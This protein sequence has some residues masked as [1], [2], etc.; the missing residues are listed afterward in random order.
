MADNYS[1]IPDG[2]LLVAVI[3]GW[4]WLLDWAGYR[5]PSLE[6]VVKPAAL[7]L[8]EDG[9]MLRQNMAKEFVTADELWGHLRDRG[10]DDLAQVK[11][12]FLEASGT[13]SVITADDTSADAP[14]RRL[15]V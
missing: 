4:A 2:V 8:V 15:P 12:A 9:R 10:I 1:S 6:R 13:V 3:L 5:F 7:L 11:Q 14:A